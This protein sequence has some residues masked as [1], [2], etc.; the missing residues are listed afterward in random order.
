VCLCPAL[1]PRQVRSHPTTFGASTRPPLKP[2]RRLPQE[3]YFRGSITRLQ[4]SLSTLRRKGCPS[5]TQ[6]SLP[7]AGQALPGRPTCPQGSNERFRSVFL[8]LI[9]L[10]QAFVA[11]GFCSF[12]YALLGATKLR[13]LQRDTFANGFMGFI[14]SVVD[15]GD[16]RS[17]G[18][19]RRS[20]GQSPSAVR[21]VLCEIPMIHGRPQCSLLM[22]SRGRHSESACYFSGRERLQR[23][24]VLYTDDHIGGMR[25]M[26]GFFGPPL[27]RRRVG[28]G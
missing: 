23:K 7:V 20:S 17:R 14:D 27:L 1:R 22:P 9:L 24:D 25:A 8:H 3:N 5:T 26:Q 16:N 10:S 11:Q 18:R 19:N 15:R 13:L 2:E 28:G 12:G 6:D 21:L 4:H